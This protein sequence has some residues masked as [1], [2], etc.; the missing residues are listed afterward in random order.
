MAMVKLS[1]PAVITLSLVL[2]IASTTSGYR[3]TIT[4]VQLEVDNQDM[5]TPEKRCEQEIKVENLQRCQAYVRHEGSLGYYLAMSTDND[6]QE[7][8]EREKLCCKE[9]KQLNEHCQCP[10]LYAIVADQVMKGQLSGEQAKRVAQKIQDLPQK[11]EAGSQ[12]C[13][14][15]SF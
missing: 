14:S 6:K 10:A 8:E 2:L 7:Q 3:T 1:V 12:R 11:C 4:T 13:L 9:L 5:G 15:K